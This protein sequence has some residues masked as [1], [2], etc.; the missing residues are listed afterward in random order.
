VVLLHHVE[1]EVEGME[2]EVGVGGKLQTKFRLL[3]NELF[4]VVVEEVE[5]EEEVVEEVEE[6][7]KYHVLQSKGY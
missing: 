7:G 2:E 4:F 3:A 6:E 1:A 5:T